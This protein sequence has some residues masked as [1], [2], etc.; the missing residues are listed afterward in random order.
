[1]LSDA[2]YSFGEDIPEEMLEALTYGLLSPNHAVNFKGFIKQLRQ[3]H[4]ITSII[5]GETKWPDLP[6]DRDILY[7]LAQSFKGYL[8]KE[9]P[10]DEA[11]IRSEHKRLAVTAKDRLKELT[12]I[13]I[14][15]AQ[16]VVG[17]NE[18]GELL[19]DW[20]LIEIA[21]DLP[22]LAGKS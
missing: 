15:I 19:P 1:M 18:N 8:M 2:L 12:R 3:K 11:S 17:P 13:S 14:E 22:R 7:F 5:K 21:R 4:T 6:S 16:S 20:F 9:L 10:N